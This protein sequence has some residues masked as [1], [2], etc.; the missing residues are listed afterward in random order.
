LFSG[1]AE[2]LGLSFWFAGAAAD[3]CS[4]SRPS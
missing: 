4:A 1:D 2:A 3:A